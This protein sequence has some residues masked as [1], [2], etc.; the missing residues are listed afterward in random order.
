MPFK[1]NADRPRETTPD[2]ELAPAVGPADGSQGI[3]AIEATFN[4][5]GAHAF[6]THPG[7]QEVIWVL[8]GRIDQ[9]IEQER[10]TLGVGD[11]AVIPE[12]AV[13][14][15]YN[16]GDVPARILAILSPCVGESG[17]GA[18]DVSGEEPWASLR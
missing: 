9:W 5:G 16:D 4:P 11:A 14:A 15:T 13:H 1:T 2:G 6:H 7:Q 12:G 10:Q 3:A 18:V 8:E 17:Y